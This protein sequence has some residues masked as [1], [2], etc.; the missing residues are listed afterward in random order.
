MNKPS[1]SLEPGSH[2]GG[3]RVP[4]TLRRGVSTFGIGVIGFM[5]A[6]LVP[7]MII[8]LVDQHGLTPT[9]AGTVMT[10]CLLSTA[11]SCLL[12]SRLSAGDGR[13]GVARAGLLLA[14]AGFGV[15][16]LVPSTP[17]AIA[18]IVLGGLGG[19]GSISASGAALA[20]LRNPN[21]MSGI[22]S[23]SNRAIV[24]VV[25]ALIPLLGTGMVSAFGLLAI[26]ALLFLGTTAWMPKALT[27]SRK[28]TFDAGTTP[29]SV[30]ARPA[31]SRK[32]TIAGF[33]LLACFGLW[34]L[35]ED[36]LWAV[37]GSMGAD[38]AGIGDQEIGLMLSASTA[39]GLLFGAAA[40]YAGDRLGRTVP[41]VVLLLLGGSLKL[42]SGLAADPTWYIV[43]IIAWNTVYA[44]AFMYVVSVAVAL[45]VRGV[46]S[47]ALSGTYL[48]GSAF[49]PLFGTFIAETLGYAPLTT[50]L[51]AFSFLLLVPFVVISRVA[52]QAEKDAVAAALT[53][54]EPQFNQAAI[55]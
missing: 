49:S 19:G 36:S 39:G 2:D 13:Y 33:S 38:Q 32:I 29:S 6:N 25:L 4:L 23:L 41:L 46:W 15:A 22:S 54:T 31:P 18:G 21:R 51:A 10:A 20:A 34:A 16:A 42:A 12:T 40:S 28:V 26:L 55:V 44:L 45:D 43:I 48:I 8:A 52:V 47:A 37:A 7:F 30:P 11:I 24:T 5:A 1:P 14:A 53:A 50:I 35:G 3:A 17:I 27:V 9:E